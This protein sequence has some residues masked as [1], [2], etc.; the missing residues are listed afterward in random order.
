[1]KQVEIQLSDTTVETVGDERTKVV[2]VADYFNDPKI[3]VEAAATASFAQINPHYPGIRATAPAELLNLL[4]DTVSQLAEAHLDQPKRDWMGQAWYS[5]VTHDPTQ[6]TPIQRLPHFDGFDEDQLAVMIYLNH[7]A[8]GG[9]AFYRQ[10]ATGYE[11]I[12]QARFPDYKVR[13]EAGV[14]AS[15]LPPAQYIRDG[16]PHFE[17]IADFG[18]AFNSLIVYPG[19]LL[20]S[21]VIDNDVP[22]PSDPRTGRLTLNGFFRPV[23]SV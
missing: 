6:L 11:R 22:L 8:H 20:H 15:G 7:T 3:I 19:T 14:R 16:A 9:T 5:I 18:A 23:R 13:L 12:T 10:Q 17:Q 21:G 1:M 2:R 4:C